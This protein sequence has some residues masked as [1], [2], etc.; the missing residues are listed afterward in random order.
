MDLFGKAKRVRV[1]LSE[2]DKIGHQPAYVALLELLRKENAQGGT[3]TRAVAGFGHTGAIHVAH[4]VDVAQDL[5]IVVEW[6]DT[7]EQVERLL[8]RIAQAAPQRLVTVEDTE[9]ALHHAG[10]S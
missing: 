5:P 10:R 3:A 1:Y 6:I 7:P 9:V 4:L 2:G 8:P